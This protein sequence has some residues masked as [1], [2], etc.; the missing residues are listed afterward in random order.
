M[1]STS[2]ERFRQRSQ[3]D[4]TASLSCRPP[5]GAFS[6]GFVV[7]RPCSRT[8]T[9]QGHGHGHGGSTRLH[10]LF[11]H[12]RR[13]IP[14][15]T[16]CAA[17]SMSLHHCRAATTPAMPVTGL[18]SAGAAPFRRLP[19]S[20]SSAHQGHLRLPPAAAPRRRRLLLRCAANSGG[21]DGAGDSGGSDP[22]LEEQRRRQAE[23]AARIASGEFTVQG[24]GSATEHRPLLLIHFFAFIYLFPVLIDRLILFR[25]WVSIH[26][27]N[28]QGGLR[29]SWGSSPSWARRGSSPPRCSPG[30][31]A[32]ARRA[33]ARRSH[34]HWGRSTPSWARPSS[35]PCTTSSSP[36]AAS[37]AST[38]DLR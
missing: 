18:S 35:C 2:G 7:S 27:F 23:L 8:G 29:L 26:S 6:S 19:A 12:H 10:V 32:L 30:W 22:A 37:F 31:P 11:H 34:R 36:T 33:A 24:P 21:G 15:S 1:P 13:L 4:R 28:H 17:L 9:Q 3:T 14:C 20:G 5:R 25:I 16:A 38:L